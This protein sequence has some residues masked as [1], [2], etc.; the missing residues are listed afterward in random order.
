[1]LEMPTNDASRLLVV[2][3]KMGLAV[4]ML[5]GA[6]VCF[7]SVG[8]IALFLLL[9]A[10]P[11]TWD[12]WAFFFGPIALLMG[13]FGALGFALVWRDFQGQVEVT[14]QGVAQITWF[15]RTFCA[16]DEISTFWYNADG[17][18]LQTRRPT[19]ATYTLVKRDGRRMR[20]AGYLLEGADK[21][22]E[23]LQAEIVRCLVPPIQQAIEAGRSV[24]FGPLEAAKDGLRGPAGTVPWRDV[25]SAELD[26]GGWLVIRRN[27]SEG[28]WFRSRMSKIPNLPVLFVLIG[29][30]RLRAGAGDLPATRE[31][32]QAPV[33]MQ[34]QLNQMDAG[35]LATLGKVEFVCDPATN[36]QQLRLGAGITFVLGGAALLAGLW[37]I[38]LARDMFPPTLPPNFVGGCCIVF[39]L[40]L[41]GLGLVLRKEAAD[42]SFSLH[43]FRDGFARVENAKAWLCG[44]QRVRRVWASITLH[45]QAGQF[46]GKSLRY[47]IERDD[48][49]K[50]AFTGALK[51]V[52]RLH[53]QLERATFNRLLDEALRTLREGRQVDFGEIQ[54]T[55]AGLRIASA[56]IPWPDEK[57]IQLRNGLLHFFQQG[58]P[59]GP[60]FCKDVANLSVFLEV[61]KGQQ[62]RTSSTAY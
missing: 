28:V 40:I 23:L 39:G 44:W 19:G 41:G 26:N 48:G 54:A 36:P 14:P 58:K 52:Q 22:D 56:E 15:S 49:E 55:R 50:V 3:G 43:V 1:V 62:S 4:A 59:V 18:Y 46:A 38:V 12:I 6:M 27:G 29:K 2:R 13:G 7:G 8:I 30:L 20:L 17:F 5:L 42:S 25:A 37:I 9:G 16:W 33:A 60:V 24:S 35:D 11:A 45:T 21:L 10:R 61:L 53:A 51:N 31:V 34:W 57:G 32:V 47:E